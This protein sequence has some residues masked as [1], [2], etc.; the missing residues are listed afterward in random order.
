MFIGGMVIVGR[1]IVALLATTAVLGIVLTSV[2]HSSAAS[3]PMVGGNHWDVKMEGGSFYFGS[4]LCGTV[5]KAYSYANDTT[6]PIAIAGQDR[7]AKV[8]HEITFDA[9]ASTDNIGIVNYTWSFVAGPMTGTL[10]RLYGPVVHFKF[11]DA[12]EYKVMLSV[13]D[14]AGNVGYDEMV[15]TAEKTGGIISVFGDDSILLAFGVV[16]VLVAVLVIDGLVRRRRKIGSPPTARQKPP[17]P[18]A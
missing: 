5:L 6:R 7:T 15:V 16:L 3:T 13:T 17:S 9:T 4:L 10:H 11:E 8:G 1:T 14:A 2:P 12:R 18:K